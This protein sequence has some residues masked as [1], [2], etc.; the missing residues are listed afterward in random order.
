[1]KK[2]LRIMI[3][4]DH[5]LVR[6]GFRK[7][8][9]GVESY[10]V[11]GEAGDGE[12]ILAKIKTTQCDILLLDL[13][14]PKVSGLKVLEEVSKKHKEIKVIVITMHKSK[15]FFKAAMQQGAMGYITKE[16]A[17][18]QVFLALKKVEDGKKYIS[19]GISEG[20]VENYIRK[21]DE[22]D[23]LPLEIFTELEIKIIELIADG[24]TSKEIADKQKVSIRTCEAHRAKILSKL[25]VK[26]TAGI[27]RYAVAKGL[28]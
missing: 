28:V 19:P 13:S 27:V 16:D 22:T 6:S 15:E 2:K 18:E 17:F 5:S 4:D 10:K 12:E 23:I 7:L 9:D 8:I 14:M 20:I 11:V 21:I 3:A 26:T 24:N 25:G 1:M